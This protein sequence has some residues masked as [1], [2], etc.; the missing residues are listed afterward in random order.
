MTAKTELRRK[1]DLLEEL[2]ALRAEIEVPA[3]N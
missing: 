1:L 3:R 2:L